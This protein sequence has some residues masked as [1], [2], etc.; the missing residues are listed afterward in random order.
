MSGSS[1]SLECHVGICNELPKFLSDS[2]EH[3]FRRFT[4]VMVKLSAVGLGQMKLHECRTSGL[5]QLSLERARSMVYSED[6][7][8]HLKTNR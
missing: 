5:G 7:A 6:V 3:F 8:T 2:G 4:T 1:R